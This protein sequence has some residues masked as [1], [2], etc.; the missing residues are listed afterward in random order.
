LVESQ[1]V[2]GPWLGT[3]SVI[4]IKWVQTV[5]VCIQCQA[6]L[7]LFSPQT[8]PINLVMRF[9]LLYEAL[10]CKKNAVSFVDILSATTL[11]TLP[12]LRA[13]ENDMDRGWRASSNQAF[14]CLLILFIPV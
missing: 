3:K 14:E 12:H 8:I 9:G 2:N 5:F 4:E 10:V 6:L 11:V 7:T 13:K 1:E